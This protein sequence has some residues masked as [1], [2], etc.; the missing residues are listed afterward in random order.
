M[1][2]AVRRLL[3]LNRKEEGEGGTSIDTVGTHKP[4]IHNND[5]DGL[6]Q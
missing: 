4:I 1:R 5:S 6:Q 2:Y 3:E